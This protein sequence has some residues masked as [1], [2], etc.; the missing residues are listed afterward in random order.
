M[1]GRLLLGFLSRHWF[2]AALVGLV[3]SVLG[4]A[5]AT[6]YRAAW[7][8]AQVETLKA[9]IASQKR[10]LDAI[11][12]VRK[13]DQ[14]AITRLEAQAA[15]DEATNEALRCL[16]AQRPADAPRGLT[17]SEL[18]LLL[19]NKTPTD[20]HRGSDDQPARPAECP[21]PGGGEGAAVR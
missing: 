16:L 12:I 13:A 17:Q 20:Q 14:D 18:D 8:Q 4:G 3:V 15:E 6:G 9:T 10:D 2:K 1:I 7:R 21:A 19:G 5:Y 11:A